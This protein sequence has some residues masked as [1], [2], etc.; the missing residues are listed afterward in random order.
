MQRFT[1][2]HK[3]REIPYV[4]DGRGG[5]ANSDKLTHKLQKDS[6][7][8]YPQA[9]LK[10]ESAQDTALDLELEYYDQDNAG[11]LR[12][13]VT[14]QNLTIDSFSVPFDGEF[15][16]TVRDSVTVTRD[17]RIAGGGGG[18]GGGS[19]GGS[20]GRRRRH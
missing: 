14:A 13:S 4:I 3:D 2:R 9:P 8:H 20:H 6:H 17:G 11:F 18:A 1:R 19:G 16:N 5:Y 12:V 10:V 7:N 15:E